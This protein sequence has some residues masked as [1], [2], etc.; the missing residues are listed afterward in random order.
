MMYILELLI[1]AE[2]TKRAL[3]EIDEISPEDIFISE[4][5]IAHLFDIIEQTR[6][7]LILFYMHGDNVDR[8]P[9]DFH[10]STIKDVVKYILNYPAPDNEHPLKGA[11]YLSA[12]YYKTEGS[13]R[14]NARFLFGTA[15][16]FRR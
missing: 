16:Q 7:K 2:N 15:S 10:E 11:H 3:Q 6:I 8:A 4:K 5:I 13:Y 1:P 9:P 12:H 14:K